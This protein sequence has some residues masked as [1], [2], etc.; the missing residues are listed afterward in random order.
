M[1]NTVKID[2]ALGGLFDFCLP[3][4]NEGDSLTGNEVRKIVGE[5]TGES[6]VFDPVGAAFAKAAL[7]RFDAPTPGE[8]TFAMRDKT[9]IEK[10][11]YPLNQV[12]VCAEIDD[13]TRRSLASV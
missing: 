7:D 2:L 13:R 6:E 8:T 5:D 3:D 12:A 10:T 4:H 9:R 1:S 11:L